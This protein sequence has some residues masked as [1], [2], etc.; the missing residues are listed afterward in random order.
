MGTHPYDTIDYKNNRPYL[1]GRQ[2]RFTNLL[3][4]FELHFFLVELSD[5]RTRSKY[6]FSF[7]ETV[8]SI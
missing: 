8:F 6:L 4:I 5:L 1:H 7:D 3:R 2:K